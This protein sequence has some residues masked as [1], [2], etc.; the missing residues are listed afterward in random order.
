[1]SPTDINKIATN[2]Q[3]NYMKSKNMIKNT[4]LLL[5][6]TDNKRR[7]YLLVPLGFEAHCPRR[8]GVSRFE[9]VM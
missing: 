5:Y 9:G 4:Y 2:C 7:N 6:F 8:I 1:M 3:K